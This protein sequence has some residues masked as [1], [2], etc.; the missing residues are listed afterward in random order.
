MGSDQLFVRGPFAGADEVVVVL[1]RD[2]AA[3]GDDGPRALDDL[4]TLLRR[5]QA[6]LELELGAPVRFAD[7]DPGIGPC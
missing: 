5:E 4:G 3:L 7:H 2:G 1:P 6:E